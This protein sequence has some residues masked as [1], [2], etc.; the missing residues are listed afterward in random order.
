MP[1]EEQLKKETEY[2]E[3][4]LFYPTLEEL[5]VFQAEWK[6]RENRRQHVCSK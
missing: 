4:E 6:A 1:T 3:K 2:A 5:K